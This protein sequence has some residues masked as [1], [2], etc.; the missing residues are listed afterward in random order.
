MGK[1]PGMGFSIIKIPS[2][3]KGDIWKSPSYGL[4][5]HD[6]DWHWA[7]D[8]YRKWRNSCKSVK[9]SIPEWFK[10]STALVAH[11]DFKYQN[12]DIVHKFKDIPKIYKQ[13]IKMGGRST[14]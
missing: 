5:I 9:L 11:Y 10:R 12:G 14:F 3:K 2:N 1:R 13:A 7:S 4:A 6:G 8:S